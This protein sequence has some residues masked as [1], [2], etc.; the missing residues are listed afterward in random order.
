MVGSTVAEELLAESV[1]A[2]LR[3][4]NNVVPDPR[5]LVVNETLQEDILVNNTS[6]EDVAEFSSVGDATG[7]PP[8]G[9]FPITIFKVLN[10]HESIELRR[11]VLHWVLNHGFGGRVTSFLAAPTGGIYGML[12]WTCVCVSFCVCIDVHSVRRCLIAK[13]R[14]AMQNVPA[15]AVPRDPRG[16]NMYQ[17]MYSIDVSAATVV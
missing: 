14:N 13:Y 8:D 1:K 4:L 9:T 17:R 15:P 7:V 16:L 5:D 11:T 12:Q 10:W 3:T 2:F 6:Q